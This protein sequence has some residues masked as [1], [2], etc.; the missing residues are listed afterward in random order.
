MLL[1]SFRQEVAIIK[2]PVPQYYLSL[3]EF[4]TLPEY[5]PVIY[6]CMELSV[7]SAGVG[8]LRELG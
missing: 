6:E 2:T 8:S 7:F 5:R 4:Y 3:Y 1:P